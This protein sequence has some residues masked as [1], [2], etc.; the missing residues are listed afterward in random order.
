MV[1]VT[2]YKFIIKHSK[3]AKRSNKSSI[4]ALALRSK[5]ILNIKG[6][7][8]NDIYDQINR[9]SCNIYV[10]ISA[11]DDQSDSAINLL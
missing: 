9:R 6:R 10:Y 2:P 4:E 3:K 8:Q 11:V 1:I 7:T 5:A